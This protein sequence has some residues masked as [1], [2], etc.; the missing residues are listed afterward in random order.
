MTFI[1]AVDI[2]TFCI[3]HNHV[4]LLLFVFNVEI[5]EFHVIQFICTGLYAVLAILSVGSHMSVGSRPSDHYFRSVCWFVCL[6][7]QSFSQP[8]LIKLGHMLYVWV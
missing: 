6:F 5:S 2:Q 3:E 7:V 4:I 8:S 1:A